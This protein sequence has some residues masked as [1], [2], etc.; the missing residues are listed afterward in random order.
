MSKRVM[1]IE[2]GV[3][4]PSAAE[5]AIETGLDYAHLCENARGKRRQADDGT[6]W[7]YLDPPVKKRPQSEESRIKRRGGN[8][9]HAKPIICIETGD[10]YEASSILAD[11]LGVDRPRVSKF[12]HETKTYNG[13]HYEFIDKGE[14]NGGT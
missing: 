14:M 12:M 7:K 5:A 8:N 9:G 3:E 2:T 6:H 10:V 4:Y 1:C 11:A 13:L